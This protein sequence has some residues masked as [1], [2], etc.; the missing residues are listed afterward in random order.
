MKR[1]MKVSKERNP[2]VMCLM[3]TRSGAHGK[4]KK[5]ER[6]AAKQNLRKEIYMDQ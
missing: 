3:T 6:K 4:T 1:K 5:A 2:I